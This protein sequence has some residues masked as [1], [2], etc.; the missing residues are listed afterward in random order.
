M[1]A[2]ELTHKYYKEK[3]ETNNLTN[4]VKAN[5]NSNNNEKCFKA[6]TKQKK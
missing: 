5:E 4:N 2:S 1:N 3:T 6:V